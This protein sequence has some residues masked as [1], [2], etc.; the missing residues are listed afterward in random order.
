MWLLGAKG[1]LNPV[2]FTMPLVK[3]IETFSKT[4]EEIKQDIENHC[5]EPQSQSCD[6]M[7]AEG[8]FFFFLLPRVKIDATSRTYKSLIS[9]SRL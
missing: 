6:T 9:F 3:I 8:I 2:K 7:T 4:A 1:A 5:L